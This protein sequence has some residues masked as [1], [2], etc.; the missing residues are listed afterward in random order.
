MRRLSASLLNA[1]NVASAERLVNKMLARYNAVVKIRH[2]S[3]ENVRLW[4]HGGDH[5]RR[6]NVG[7]ELG[8]R[9]D[10][11]FSVSFEKE[12]ALLTVR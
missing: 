8:V 12:F 2:L 9:V 1:Q 6:I 5:D 7:L 3:V 4:S 11:L 10:C